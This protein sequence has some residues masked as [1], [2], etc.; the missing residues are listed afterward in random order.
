MKFVYPVCIYPGDE[1]GY[2]VVVPDLPGCVTEGK[3]ISD[4]LEQVIDA[5]SGWI[6]DEMEDGKSAPQ[7]SLTENVKADEYSGGFVSVIILDID[8]YA[9]NMVQ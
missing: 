8:A 5:A 2:T 3:T 9:E 1:S 4:A 6:L 7:P